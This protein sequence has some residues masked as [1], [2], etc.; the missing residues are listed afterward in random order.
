M[1]EATR[2]VRKFAPNG[3]QKMGRTEN[4]HIT[5][6][7]ISDARPDE[8]IV[9]WSGDHIYSFDLVRHPSTGEDK[10]SASKGKGNTGRVK[11][12]MSGKRKRRSNESENSTA[13]ASTT[14]VVSRPRT[15]DSGSETNGEG[16]ATA[17]R[18]RYQNGQQEDIPIPDQ[19]RNRQPPMPL[20]SKQKDAQRIA[21]ATVRIRS[22]LFSAE[23]ESHEPSIAFTSALG[24]SAS[25]LSDMDQTVRD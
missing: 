8:M 7:K 24:L 11:G 22:S 21:R 12:G 9:S 15:S 2:C 6:L 13:Q 19:G 14:R 16:Q 3:Q 18:I 4:G 17:L 1:A 10:L 23:N 5:A 25:I 20:T